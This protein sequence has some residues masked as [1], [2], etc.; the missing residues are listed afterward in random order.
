MLIGKKRQK[1]TLLPAMEG[2]SSHMVARTN[3]LIIVRS[4]ENTSESVGNLEFCPFLAQIPSIIAQVFNIYEQKQWLT[5]PI[6]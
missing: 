2:L 5:T 4:A 6:F 3:A 1:S